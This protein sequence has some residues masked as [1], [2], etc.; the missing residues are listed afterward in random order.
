MSDTIR[1]SGCG[2]EG[3]V[4]RSCPEKVVIEMPDQVVGS[5]KQRRTGGTESEQQEKQETGRQPQSDQAM[6]TL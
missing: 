4:V 3:H 2:Q 1:C 6:I 5:S